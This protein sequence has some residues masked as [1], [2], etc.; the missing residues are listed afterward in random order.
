[1]PGNHEKVLRILAELRGKNVPV[2]VRTI[3]SKPNY[4]AIEM[5]TETI[6]TFP[7]V[8][9][10]S[11]LEFSS[12]GDGYTNRRS[13]ELERPVFDE[14]VKK[15]AARHSGPAR[16]DVYRNENKIGTYAL[17]TAGGN[18]YGTV[19]SPNDGRYPIVGSMIQEHLSLLA[20]RLPFSKENHL[21]RYSIDVARV[22]SEN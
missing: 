10:W 5:M 4:E 1:M 15:V 14:V 2:I 22:A 11:L 17:V 6:D 18:L 21:N 3:V 20:G 7:N 9:R 13:Y 8:V 19:I 12:I 16:L